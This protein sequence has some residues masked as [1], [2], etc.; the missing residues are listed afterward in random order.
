MTNCGS[1]NNESCCTSLLVPGGTYDRTYI[2]QG[3]GPMDAGDPA[4]V[5]SFRLDKYLVTVG[6]FR[7]FVNAVAGNQTGAP[8]PGSGKHTHLNGG[9]GM[10]N[11]ADGTFEQG[12]LSVYDGDFAPTDA[13]LTACDPYPPSTWTSPA[14]ARENLPIDCVTWEEAY[15]FCIWDGGFLPSE[16]EWEYAAA[17]GSELREYAWGDTPP[18][19]TNQYAIYGCL[20][21]P[22]DGG[23]CTGYNIAN[24]APVGTA[25]SG[26]GKWGHLD[27]IG[28]M[29]EYTADWFAPYVTPCA[30]CAYL[31]PGTMR[32]FRGGW[33]EITPSYTSYRR[34]SDY[35]NLRSSGLGMRCARSP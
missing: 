21:N 28:D 24:V 20:F 31:N 9:S 2:N 25:T 10:I 8:M 13:N 6:R 26:V 23:A 15:A 35:P 17:G 22:E 12:W 30:D 32:V 16:A 11:S 4:T 33:Y 3:A 7:Q 19:T 5:S 14:P 29:I 34:D 27:L 18:G 1:S